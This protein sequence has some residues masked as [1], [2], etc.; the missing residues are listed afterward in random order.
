MNFQFSIQFFRNEKV[1]DNKTWVSTSLPRD[2]FSGKSQVSRNDA[3]YILNL[4]NVVTAY[5]QL[6]TSA[7]LYWVKEHCIFNMLH[8]TVHPATDKD[9]H[10][11]A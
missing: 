9:T 6:N 3:A 2:L 11:F 7:A 1:S 8:S 5:E 10:S 4:K